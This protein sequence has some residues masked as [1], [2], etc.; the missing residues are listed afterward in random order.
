MNIITDR[1]VITRSADQMSNACGCSSADGQLFDKAKNIFGKGKDFLDKNQGIKDS[2]GGL[3]NKGTGT[4]TPAPE[5]VSFTPPPT[6]PK[7]KGMSKGLKVGLIVGASVLVLVIVG[8]VA[9]QK[10]K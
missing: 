7:A 1:K 6:P 4:K 2:L 9:T 5:P 10:K 3:I 8:V